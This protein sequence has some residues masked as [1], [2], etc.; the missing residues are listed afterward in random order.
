[1]VKEIIYYNPEGI[2]SNLMRIYHE[3]HDSLETISH[4]A[5]I[6]FVIISKHFS[7]I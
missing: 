3:Y 6:V 7:C 1:M 5:K 4:I 2:L